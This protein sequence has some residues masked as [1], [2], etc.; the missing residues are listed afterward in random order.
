MI[1]HSTIG[2]LLAVASAASGA[3]AAA[4]A[5]PAPY[6]AEQIRIGESFKLKSRA[7]G[8][9]RTVNVYLPP[10]YSEGG[11]Y[12]VLYLIDGGLQQDFLHIVGTS[13]LGALWGRSKE[14]IVVGV[15]TRDRRRELVGPTADT[16]LL[17][18]YPTA[19]KSEAFR[20]YLRQE[21]MPIIAGR[22]R[23]SGYRAVI[24]ESL[25]GLFIV[26]TFLRAPDMFDAYAA[27]SPSLWWD[28]ERLSLEAA[29]L[30]GPRH[31]G[32]KI[33]VAIAD[34]GGE[35]Q[36]AA[37]RLVSVLRP[38][39]RTCYA[40]RPALTHATI[41]HSVSPEALQYLFPGDTPPDPQS[42]FEVPCSPKS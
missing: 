27:V 36:A 34:E 39:G 19:G 10:S 1:F 7:L 35:M 21:V 13:Q 20:Q 32:R 24:G 22:Y 11:S 3:V 42:G 16:S 5:M 40:P 23:T 29:Q 30:V 37:D 2:L 25:A 4:P 12:P 8:E 17:A 38:L 15:E 9:E 28:K 33:Y 6:E 41:Y 18:K 31:T 26:E 14:V